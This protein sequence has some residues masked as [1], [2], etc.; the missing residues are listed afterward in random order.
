M[1]WGYR[2]RGILYAVLDGKFAPTNKE[3]DDDLFDLLKKN[4]EMLRWY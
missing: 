4:D 3:S 1:K 2:K